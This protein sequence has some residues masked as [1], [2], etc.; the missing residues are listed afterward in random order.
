MIDIRP[1]SEV[2]MRLT[3]GTFVTV[4][5]YSTKSKNLFIAES[6]D[7]PGDW[8]IIFTSC[9][10]SFGDFKKIVD[11]YKAVDR[12]IKLK[13]DYV[14]IPLSVSDTNL[15]EEDKKWLLETSRT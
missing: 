5:A 1:E 6:H 15:T 4:E 12:L 2:P 11:A 8:T 14:S 13:L 3:D 7:H 9:G 10:A